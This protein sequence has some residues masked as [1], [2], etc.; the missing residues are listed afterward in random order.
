MQE[1]KNIRLFISLIVLSMLTVILFTVSY[2]G[3]ST[4]VDKNIFKVSDQTDV[5]KVLLQSKQGSIE[6]SYNR[7]N[8]QVN[9]KFD[10]DRQLIKVFFAMI[11]QA[12]A[13]RKITGSKVDSLREM[14]VDQGIQV[15]LFAGDDIMKEFLVLGNPQKSETYFK[16]TDSPEVYVVSIPGYRV[17]L[18]SIFELKANDWR[19]KRIFNFNWQNFRSL[20]ATFPHDPKQNFTISFK[21]QFFGIDDMPSADTTKLNNYLDAV[22]LVQ[23]DRI[24]ESNEGDSLGNSGP[25]F[26]IDIRDIANRSYQLRVFLTGEKKIGRLNDS[27]LFELNPR[28]LENIGRGKNYFLVK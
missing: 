25:D 4:D 13:K 20:T 6:L 8:W 15:K 14:M 26:E 17:Y 1:K 23:G 27:T 28:A 5:D 16:L 7:V 10:A 9:K 12:E 21:D 18:A 2:S 19:D 22:S 3:K 11:Y 24:L